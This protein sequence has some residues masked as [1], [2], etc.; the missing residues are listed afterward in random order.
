MAAGPQKPLPARVAST[1]IKVRRAVI[2][3]RPPIPPSKKRGN[4]ILDIDETFVQYVGLDDWKSLSPT[5]Q[6]KYEVFQPKPTSNGLFILRP[7]VS[8]FFYFLSTHC[9]T[10]SLW[11]LSDKEYADGVKEMIEKRFC[12]KINNVWSEEENEPARDLYKN[13][14]DLN[15]LWYKNPETIGK[16]KPCNTILIDDLIGNTQNTSNYLNGIR[17][18]AF[19]PLGHK[20]TSGK[21]A[22]HIRTNEYTDSSDDTILLEVIAELI[23]IF[24]NKAWCSKDDEMPFPLTERVDL[25]EGKKATGGRKTRRRKVGKKTRKARKTK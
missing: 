20:L 17:I 25:V 6:G 18:P 15:Y 11:T 24:E 10:V 14:K 1:P 9:E 22:T 21:T 2:P 4:I 8:E 19:A 16:F 7:N 23:E 3:S 5:E 13:N 12:V